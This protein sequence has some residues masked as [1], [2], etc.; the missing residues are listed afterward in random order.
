MALGT[1]I[2]HETFEE[3]PRLT[4]R[5]RSREAFGSNLE[6]FA[7]EP[8][9]AAENGVVPPLRSLEETRD[10]HSTT[11]SS[12]RDV[13]PMSPGVN[14]EFVS[15]A[16]C[17]RGSGIHVPCIYTHTRLTHSIYVHM[18]MLSRH[19]SLVS[20]HCFVLGSLES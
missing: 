19:C 5:A 12:P 10:R 7:E 6:V 16:W 17:R 1:V 18:C 4:Y 20:Q 2:I 3:S 13:S 9:L 15:R 14:G 11:G 8:E